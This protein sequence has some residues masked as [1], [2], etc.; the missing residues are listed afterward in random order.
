MPG[1]MCPRQVELPASIA[2]LVCLGRALPILVLFSWLPAQGPT[3]EPDGFRWPGPDGQPLPFNS[4]VDLEDFLQTAKIVEF[5]RTQSGITRPRKVTLERDGVRMHAIFR[6]IDDFKPMWKGPQGTKFDFHDSCVHEFVGYRLTRLLEWNHLPPVVLRNLGADDFSPPSLI[7]KFDGVR[8]GSLQAWVEGAMTEVDRSKR[9][10][11]PPDVVRWSREMS[12]MHL[13]DNLV[14]NEDRNQTNILIGSDWTIWYIDLTRAF[15]PASHLP[16]PEKIT[17]CDRRL[18]Q[19]IQELKAED[20]ERELGPW[21][22]GR[23]LT[24]L[25]RRHQLL[26]ERIEQLIAERGEASVLVDLN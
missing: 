20:F 16:T 10:L 4:V 22:R 9:N 5:K 21:I 8:K 2:S 3:P 26:R 13:F 23:V 14:Y 25:I 12:L 19:R 24:G 11:L 7:G 6:N 1:S 18:W 17:K 15:R